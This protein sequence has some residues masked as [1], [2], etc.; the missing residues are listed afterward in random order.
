M[1]KQDTTITPNGASDRKKR[2]RKKNVIIENTSSSS[3]VHGQH[4]QHEEKSEIKQ[5]IVIA[6]VE[7]TTEK[8]GKKKTNKKR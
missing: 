5:N 6:E 1:D 3:Q 4:E 2:G 7:V 8:K